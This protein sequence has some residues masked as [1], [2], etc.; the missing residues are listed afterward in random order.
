MRN[1]RE[2]LMAV[3]ERESCSLIKVLEVSFND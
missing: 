2:N 1:K 3:R